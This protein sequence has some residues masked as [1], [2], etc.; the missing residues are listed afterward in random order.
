MLL[1]SEDLDELRALCDRIVVLFRGEV[2]GD[3]DRGRR[4]R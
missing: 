1:V 3:A 4:E 2:V